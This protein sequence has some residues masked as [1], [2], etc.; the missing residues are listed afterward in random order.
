[1]LLS[2]WVDVVF[3]PC[4][5]P[6]SGLLLGLQK[7][8]PTPPGVPE[9][10]SSHHAS[11]PSMRGVLLSLPK[12]L[13]LSCVVLTLSGCPARQATL[14]VPLNSL[15]VLQGP[16]TEPVFGR[17]RAER[18]L[19]LLPALQFISEAKRRLSHFALVALGKGPSHS[20]LQ[21]ER[22]RVHQASVPL[23]SF[24]LEFGSWDFGSLFRLRYEYI[25]P[26]NFP[27]TEARR[28]LAPSNCGAHLVCH[29]KMKVSPK[30]RQFLVSRVS[31]KLRSHLFRA[32]PHSS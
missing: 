6:R 30:V 10:P 3:C 23:T 25:F 27:K 14:C 29:R 15:F 32:S 11:S 13:P 20:L 1:M 4:H 21:R 5:H 22:Q 18:F 8:L 28:Y 2:A 9:G 19:C 7:P 31:P 12:Q 17:G 26:R 16:A 24:V